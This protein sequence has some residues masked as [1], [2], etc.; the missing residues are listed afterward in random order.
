[1]G[2]IDDLA[3]AA[4]GGRELDACDA[5]RLVA[6]SEADPFEL[7]HAANRIRRHFKGDGV[8]LC[9]IVNARSGGCSEDCRFCAQSSR[10][11]TGAAR[12]AMLDASMLLEAGRA[13]AGLGAACFGIVT[14][15]RGPGGEGD[16]A[17][18]GEVAARLEG[19]RPSASLGSLTPEVAA[20]LRAAGLRRYHHNLE[21]ARSF[22]PEVCTTHTYDD[23]LATV[24]TAKAAGFEVCCGGIFGLGESWRHRIELAIELRGLG[25]ESVPVNFLN[26]VPG[27]PLEGREPL[28]ALE[29]LRII[30]LYRFLLPRADIRTAGGRGRCLGDLQS[31]MF[32]AGANAT[33]IGNYLTTAG[34]PPEQDLA[35]IRGLGLRIERAPARERPGDRGKNG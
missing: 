1:M 23:R 35:M 19:V 33:M 22:F 20:R 11:R 12:Y 17:A 18:V 4:I 13:A 7:F 14:S 16:V 21:T 25:V 31:W 29:G 2:V 32:Y 3:S 28:P 10:H 24:R 9:S 27:T 5:G 30:A 26:P 34:R 6:A 8:Q 15:G